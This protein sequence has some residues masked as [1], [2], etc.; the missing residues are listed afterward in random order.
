M[1]VKTELSE[2]PPVF[3][4]E[5]ENQTAVIIFYTDVAEKQLEEGI[6]YTAV[7]WVIK[8]P[9]AEN[10]RERIVADTANWLETAKAES[11]KEAAAAVRAARNDLLSGTD[12]DM[13]L[14]RLGLNAPSG[15]TFTAWLS[16]LKTI[17]EAVGGSMAKYRQQL[18]DIT[19]QAGFPY[20]VTWPE[21]PAK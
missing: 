14:D 6:A 21:K 4:V 16:F 7:S 5:R 18:R 1:R 9:W 11:Y 12:A 8:R 3:T 13:A 20:E 19:T 10:L 2:M 17:G 15:T